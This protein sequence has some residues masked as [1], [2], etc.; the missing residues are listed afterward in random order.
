MRILLTQGKGSVRPAL[1]NL[2]RAISLKPT[3]GREQ[4]VPRSRLIPD[5]RP[6]LSQSRLDSPTLATTP[7]ELCLRGDLLLKDL[8]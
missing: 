4:G 8:P 7:T 1:F 3:R 6:L 5:P 2:Q